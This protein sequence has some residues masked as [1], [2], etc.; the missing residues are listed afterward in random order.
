LVLLTWIYF[1]LT[2]NDLVVEFRYVNASTKG[3]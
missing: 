1:T 3:F 2:I